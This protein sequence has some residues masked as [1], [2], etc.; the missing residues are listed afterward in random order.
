MKNKLRILGLLASLFCVPLLAQKNNNEEQSNGKSAKVS[1]ENLIQSQ[2]D[3]YV[4]THEHTSSVSGTRHVY[5]RQAINGI[6]IYGTESSIHLDKSGAKIIEHNKFITDV[7]A[8]LKSNTQ[9][10]SAAQAIKS[11]ATQMQYAVENLNQLKAPSGPNKGAVFDGGRT[12]VENIPVELM[13]IY[14][15]DSGIILGWQLS[16]AEVNSANWWNFIVDAGTGAIIK[17]T[18]WVDECVIPHDHTTETETVNFNTNLYDIPNYKEETSINSVSCTN[19]YEVFAMPVESPYFGSRT[20]VTDPADA[21]ASPF[22]W[23]DTDGVAG[24]EFTTT[25]G[26]NV[27]AFEAGDNPGYQPDGGADLHFIGYAFGQDYSLAN[28]YEDA[29]ITNL[30]YWNNIIHDVLYQYGFD[31]ASGN[32]QENNYGNG[33]LGSDSVNG[34]AQDGSETCNARFGT[35]VDGSNPTMRMFICGDK[36]GDFEGLV[37]AHEYGHGISNRLTGGAGNSDCLDNDEQMGEGWSDFYGY[38]L[39][40]E[41]GDTG[42]DARGVGMYL[43]DQGANGSGIRNFMYSTDMV[44]NPH[45]YDDI[46][47][48]GGSPHALGEVWATMLWDLTWGLIDAYGFDADFYNFTG[49]VNQDAGNVQAMAI[50]TEALKLQPCSPGFIDGRDAIFAADAAIYGGANECIIWGAF[51]RRGLG[52]SATQGSTNSRVDGTEAFDTPDPPTAVCVAPFSIVVDENGEVNLTVADIDNGSFDTCGIASMSISPSEF[53]C[54]DVGDHEVTLTVIDTHGN[55]DTCVTTVTVEKRATVLTYT[56]DLSEQYSDQTDLSANLEDFE[57][58]PLAGRTITFTIGTQSVQAVT[59]ANGDAATT[60]ILTQNPNVPYT[61]DIEV[62]EE[63]CYLGSSDSDVFDILQEDAIVEY[64][65]HT[66]QATP[67]EN[68]SVATVVLSA[69]IQDISVSDPIGDPYPGDIQNAMVKFVNRDTNTDISGWIPVT[70]LFDPNDPTTGTVSYDWIVDIGNQSSQTFTVGILV[71]SLDDN[72]Y[73]YRDSADD[74][75]LVTVYIPVGDF[76]TGGGT[77]HPDNSAGSYASTDG[78]KLNFG[79]NVKFNNGGKKLKGHANVIFRILQGDGV[80]T[81]QIKGNAIQSLGVNIADEN[82]K[83]AEFVT[84]ANLT[85]VTDPLNPISLGGN[86]KLHVDMTDRG[87]PGSEDEISFNLT[88]ANGILLYSSNWTGIETEEMFLSGGNIVVHSG[89]SARPFLAIEDMDTSFENILLYPNP[90]KN[91]IYIS[92]PGASELSSVDIYDVQGRLVQFVDIS[93]M[94]TDVEIDISRLTSSTYFFII[95]G[96]EGQTIKQVVKE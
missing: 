5:L 96:A 17:K 59:D 44:V 4:I 43:F 86:L 21:T 53:T 80:H 22:G 41:A 95:L 36:D 27:S 60:L 71:G 13:Y 94:K 26:N 20:I 50:V 14:Q 28:Q 61:V 51:A 63:A 46:K 78:L 47:T 64:T 52:L 93:D 39:T 7:S 34:R 54:A 38:M 56:G 91:M 15:E 79:F 48:T 66:F 81:Y 85:D 16:I 32:F 1:L 18:S 9:S 57:G 40:M 90:A 83:L 77:I 58:N 88:T 31:E 11:V 69:N 65:G 73:Y 12:S 84:K 30:F 29:A 70:D 25:Q 19:C 35:P 3:T 42:V 6:G 87:E 23:H 2:K 24:A 62:D 75:T 10:L 49:D 55:E 82:N 89:F 33:G 72:G 67:N 74:N 8:Q 92:N 37:I 45:T 68:S 76:I